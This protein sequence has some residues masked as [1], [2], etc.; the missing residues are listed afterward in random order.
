MLKLKEYNSHK[1][2]D[3]RQWVPWLSVILDL[4]FSVVQL[5]IVKDN[6]TEIMFGLLASLPQGEFDSIYTSNYWIKHSSWQGRSLEFLQC[7]IAF[8]SSQ[9]T[10]LQT[11]LKL[12]NKDI[13]LYT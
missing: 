7:V 2:P 11:T 6:T 4:V 13:K 3:M 9:H 5:I 1:P 10:H 8:Y 12:K